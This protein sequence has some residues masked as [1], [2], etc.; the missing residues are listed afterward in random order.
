[1]T[2]KINPKL[3]DTLAL[4]AIL[5]LTC[6]AY[7]NVFSNQFLLDDEFLLQKNQ[8]LNSWSTFF[9]I[10]RLSSTGGAGGI[11]S[12]YR[13][14]QTVMYLIF[15]QAFGFNTESFHSLNLLL[16]LVNIALIAALGLKLGFQRITVFCAAAIWAA[17]PLH[18]EAVTYMSATADPLHTLFCLLGL[19]IAAP[20]FSFRKILLVIPIY[21]LGLL[22][23]EAAIVFPALLV[24][25]YFFKNPQ[26]YKLRTYVRTW[27]LWL[28]AIGYLALR[29][30]VLN[31]DRTFQ[32]YKQ[33][34]L[35]TENI[36]Y[37][38]FTFFATI[39]HY[40]RLFFWPKDLHLER[41]FSVYTSLEGPVVLGLIFCLLCLLAI[42][43]ERKKPQKLF[44]FA[45][46]WLLA[47]HITQSGVLVPVNAFFLEHWMYM[48]CI[49]P[50]MIGV[51][52]LFQKIKTP[53]L[54]MGISSLL[55]LAALGLACR[56]YEQNKT[57]A[58]PITF[59]NHILATEPRPPPRVYNNLGMAYSSRGD[60]VQ[61]QASYE[62]AIQSSDEY[63]QTRHNLAL[64]LLQT[65]KIDEALQHFE[66][67]IQLNPDFYHSYSYMAEIYKI[68]KQPEMQAEYLRKYEETRR[69]FGP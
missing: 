41:S 28:V 14:L 65:G 43:W 4:G 60:L 66:R 38:I 7:S 1:M 30:T 53:R 25:C 50:L 5:I 15:A 47:S 16:H 40:I 39:P 34:N 48:V 63:P 3:R 2:T 27:P 59:Y 18:T 24:A 67:A 9:D 20:D 19:L 6:L 17:H 44:T 57:W 56:T 22:S 61:A 51:E 68:K 33:S 31:F 62:K 13:P 42:F 58:D 49:F 37:R 35:Y 64:L 26:P 45:T 8:L 10:F 54:H 69:R 23:K 11:D 52:F 21:I 55:A 32:F 29:Q 12:F 36:L 46:L